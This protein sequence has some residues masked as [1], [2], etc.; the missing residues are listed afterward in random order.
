V[1]ER[2]CSELRAAVE[3]S[4]QRNLCDAV[5]LSGGLD[6]SIIASIAAK[7]INLTGITVVYENAPDLIYARIIA[8]KYSI[9]HLIKHLTALDVDN[10]IENVVRIM[11]TF[12]PME[13]RNTSVLY[14]SLKELR[15]NGFGSVMTGDG[16]DELFVGYNYMMRL[17]V[18]K[19]ESELQKLWDV[20][21]FSSI[22]IGKEL[23]ISV[24][25]PY[26][27][28]EFLEFSERIPTELKIR[29]Q[30]GS[31]YGKWILRSCFEDF[32][33]KDVAWRKKMPL[34]EGA[35]LDVFATRFNSA[36][37]NTDFAEKIKY[38]SSH[39]SVRIRNKEHLHYYT[40]YRKFFDA[41]KSGECEYRCPDCMGCVNSDSRFCKTCGAFPIKPIADVKL[42]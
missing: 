23:G 37:S 2:R 30:N 33:T 20:M 19:L 39:D 8:E 5:L 29:R 38:H 36:I 31:N 11:K 13:I 15:N 28:K 21:H 41:P 32:V 7:L 26:L 12:D 9:R 10:A 14:T 40:I 22:V 34:E 6:S 17:D 42:V 35:G 24:K 1:L 3:S 27:D 25:T 4:V 18:E 16:G